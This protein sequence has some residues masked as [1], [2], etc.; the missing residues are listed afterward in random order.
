MF[1]SA[2][3]VMGDLYASAVGTT[4]LQFKEVPDRPLEYD[5]LLTLGDVRPG[6]AEEAIRA[7]LA[8]FGEVVSVERLA[9]EGQARVAFISHDAVRKALAAGAIDG[10]CAW[11]AAVYNDRPYNERGWCAGTSC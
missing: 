11:L 4:V 5:G 2:L 1:K 8:Q 9:D 3:S 10:L 7:A 6:K